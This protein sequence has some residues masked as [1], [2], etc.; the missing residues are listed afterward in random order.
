MIGK[1]NTTGNQARLRL[2][3]REAALISVPSARRRRRR[4]RRKPLRGFGV[5]LAGS[6][7]PSAPN[8]LAGIVV[9]ARSLPRLKTLA[10]NADQ[11]QG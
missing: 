1:V 5:R 2:C 8:V 4:W 10:Q 3:H 11:V 6:G 9:R 7:M